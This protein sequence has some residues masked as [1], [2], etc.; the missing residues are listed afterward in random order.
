MKAVA[1]QPVSNVTIARAWQSKKQWVPIRVTD[2]GMQID[3]SELQS[4]KNFG[5]KAATPES[6][7]N[8][9]LR[10]RFQPAKAHP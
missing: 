5:R 7:S 9:R 6:L 1:E 3:R 8:V 2:E 4:E 10:S